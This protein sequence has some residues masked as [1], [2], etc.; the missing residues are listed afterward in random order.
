MA[1]R[2]RLALRTVAAVAAIIVLV[3][4]WAPVVS[5]EVVPGGPAAG[6]QANPP[7]STV[8]LAGT[9]SGQGVSGVM[10]TLTPEQRL[11]GYPGTVDPSW[12]RHDVGFAGLIK[13]RVTA[14]PGTGSEFFSYCIDILTPTGI[15]SDYKRGEWTE[16]GIPNVGYVAQLLQSYFPTTGQPSSL[17]NVNARA[18]AVQSAI[19]YFSDGYV[20]A[21]NSP[22]FATVRSIVTDVIAPRAPHRAACAHPYRHGPIERTEEHHRRPVRRRHKRGGRCGARAYGRGGLRR[23]CW[24]RS[25]WRGI[26]G[27]RRRRDLAAFR[28]GRHQEPGTHH[29]GYGDSARGRRLRVCAATVDPE[30]SC[31]NDHSGGPVD[32]G[33]RREHTCRVSRH[34]VVH[35]HEVDHR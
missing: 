26:P 6:T 13:M 4:A 24:Q 3:V 32:S 2:S 33:D 25:A 23:R 7:T 16:A 22:L 5:A 20:L 34:R 19:W 35:D 30:R 1:K 28:A 8:E 10:S 9:G 15:G 17:T 27:R 11:A 14:G 31:A 18:A 29:H 12:P 21:S